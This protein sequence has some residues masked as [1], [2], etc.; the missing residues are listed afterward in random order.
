MSLDDLNDD[1]VKLVAYTIVSVKRDKE[2]VLPKGTDQIVIASNLSSEGFTSMIIAQY[3][4]SQ[5][6]KDL[7]EDE[8][9]K[10]DDRKYLRVHYVVSRRWPREPIRFEERHIDVLAGIRDAIL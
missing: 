3:F 5:N 7:A 9:V 2:R 6:Y 8:K 1:T 4:Q 10:E